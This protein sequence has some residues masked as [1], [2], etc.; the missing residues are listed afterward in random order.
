MA[1]VKHIAIIAVDIL[2]IMKITFQDA[3]KNAIMMFA[4]SAEP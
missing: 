4:L 1:T 3:K 2:L